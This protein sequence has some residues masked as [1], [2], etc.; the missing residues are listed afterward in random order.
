MTATKKVRKVAKRAAKV[1]KKAR[2]RV[3]GKKNKK[4]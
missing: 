2:K 1:A 4:G 3:G